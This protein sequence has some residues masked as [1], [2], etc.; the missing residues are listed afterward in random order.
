[1]VES[2]SEYSQAVKDFKEGKKYKPSELLSD[3]D[4]IDLHCKASTID[5]LNQV[6]KT[7][8]SAVNQLKKK[9]E[10]V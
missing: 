4:T 8:K 1:M 9:G 7:L 3:D 5:F 10:N 6:L 2:L